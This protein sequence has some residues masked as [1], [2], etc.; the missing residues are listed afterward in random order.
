MIQAPTRVGV[1]LAVETVERLGGWA[2][3][4]PAYRVTNGRA[5]EAAA[6]VEG[7]LRT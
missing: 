2:H 1:P 5:H 6:W 7:L 4:I 3:T